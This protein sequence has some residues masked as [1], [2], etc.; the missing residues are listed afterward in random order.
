MTQLNS[1]FLTALRLQ[2]DFAAMARIGRTPIGT[3]LIAPVLGG[4]FEGPR[5][6]GDVLPGGPTG[7]SIAAKTACWSMCV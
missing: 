1:Q 3:R 5:L 2:V 7:R 6:T 4:R